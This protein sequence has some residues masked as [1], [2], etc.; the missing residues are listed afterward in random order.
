[1]IWPY[2]KKE[3]NT[4][5]RTQVSPVFPYGAVHTRFFLH[6]SIYYVG[7]TQSTAD[8]LAEDYVTLPHNPVRVRHLGVLVPSADGKQK[9]ILATQTT[10]P[11][12]W[13]VLVQ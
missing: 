9:N 11:S 7:S 4:R 3:R 8:F 6:H 1:M 5:E 10:Y 13:N 12:S 2:R